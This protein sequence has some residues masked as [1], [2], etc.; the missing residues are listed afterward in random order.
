MIKILITATVLVVTANAFFGSESDELI[1]FREGE[2]LICTELRVFSY[3]RTHSVSLDNARVTYKHTAHGSRNT[4]IEMDN[5]IEFRI[6]DCS[7]K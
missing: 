7:I 1:A 3:N 6:S 5:G 2:T 4:Y